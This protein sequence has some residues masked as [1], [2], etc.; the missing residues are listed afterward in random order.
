M[1]AELLGQ[2]HARVEVAGAVELDVA[3]EGRLAEEHARRQQAADL[4]HNVKLHRLM[5]LQRVLADPNLRRVWWIA[6]FPDRFNDLED[7]RFT[8]ELV[9]AHHRLAHPAAA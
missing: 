6:R 5:Q 3:S 2:V 1:L 8:D 7:Q 4:E 9:T